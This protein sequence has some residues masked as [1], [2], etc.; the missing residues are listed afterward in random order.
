MN[1]KERIAWLSEPEHRKWKFIWHI[2]ELGIYSVLLV[3]CAV[4]LY[5][6]GN[7]EGFQTFY[8]LLTIGLAISCALSALGLHANRAMKRWHIQVISFGFLSGAGLCAMAGFLILVTQ[9]SAI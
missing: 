3:V 1:L 5:F 6:Y 4:T 2:T 9:R 8:I 7:G